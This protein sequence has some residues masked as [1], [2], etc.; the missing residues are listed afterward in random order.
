MNTMY[1]FVKP[2]LDKKKK[3]KKKKKE[4]KKKKKCLFL[5]NMEPLRKANR[6]MQLCKLIDCVGV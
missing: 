2:C 4:K 5:R 1:Q 6:R 3:K